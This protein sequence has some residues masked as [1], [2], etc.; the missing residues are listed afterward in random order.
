ME[1]LTQNSRLRVSFELGISRIRRSAN[2]YTTL[3]VLVVLYRSETCHLALREEY[4][5]GIHENRVLKR[6][7]G[8]KI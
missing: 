2:Y 7:Y 1:N 3:F 5:L 6:I 8:P 4:G